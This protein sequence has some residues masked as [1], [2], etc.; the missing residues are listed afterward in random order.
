MYRLCFLAVNLQ[1]VLLFLRVVSCCRKTCQQSIKYLKPVCL[2]WQLLSRNQAP[3]KS[4]GI[5]KSC[6]KFVYFNI[7]THFHVQMSKKMSVMLLLKNIIFEKPKVW[8]R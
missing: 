1:L 7:K 3:D 5:F 8:L 6:R 2:C 4:K